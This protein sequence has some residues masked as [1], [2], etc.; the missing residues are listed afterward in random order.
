MEK[1]DISDNE[2]DDS[3]FA[4]IVPLLTSLKY[5][6]IS[7]NSITNIPDSIKLMDKLEDLDISYNNIENM[8]PIV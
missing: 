8:Y 1:L 3:E 4:L 5:L 7:G 6:D 2:I